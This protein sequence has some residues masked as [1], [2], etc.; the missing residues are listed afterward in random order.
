MSIKQTQFSASPSV[1]GYLYQCRY[2]LLSALSRLRTGDEFLLHLE[3]LD[4]VVFETAGSPLEILQTKHH[5]ART[6]DLT[7]A[8][9]DLWKTLRIWCE[10]TTTNA[11][12]SGTTFYL[13]TTSRAPDGSAASYLKIASRNASTALQRLEATAQ[14]STNK[15]NRA[16][17]QAFLSLQK[18]QREDLIS[19]VYIVDYSPSIVD[20][21]VR[22]GEEIHWAVESDFRTS[23]LERL[24][25]WWFRRSIQHLVNRSSTPILSQEIEAQMGDLREQFKQDALPIDEDIFDLEID[26]ASAYQNRPFVH[27][28]S[29][30][31][32]S[33]KRILFAIRDYFRAYEQR[34]RW[35]REDLL[36]V[37][38]LDHYEKRLVEEWEGS[39]SSNGCVRNLAMTLQKRPNRKQPESSISGS[40]ML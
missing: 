38:E 36:L 25:G 34:S 26:D 16:A 17:Y 2:A 7:D 35:V 29:L 15:E 32:I 40:K 10:S 9:A 1:I 6:A 11:I 28:L 31:G 3:T 37:G 20:L 5:L 13:V 4:D 8:S 33:T 19:S 22:L 27:Q 23:F 21:D 39:A 30:I 18:R 14:T 12:P 24:E